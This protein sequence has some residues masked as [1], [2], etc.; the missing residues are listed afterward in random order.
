[1]IL[2]GENMFNV[3]CRRSLLLLLAV[4]S[5]LIVSCALSPQQVTIKPDITVGAAGYGKGRAISVQAEDLRENP[6]IGT[7]GGVYGNTST[8]EIGN[9]VKSEIA[10]AVAK[11][12]GNWGFK[13]QVNG[14]DQT[15]TMVV[16]LSSLTYTLDSNP[17]IGKAHVTATIT[18]DVTQGNR[19]YHGSYGAN[20]EVGYIAPPPEERN[21][22]QIN[23][24]I[25][26]ALQKVF[27][28]E[29]L[30]NFLQ[31]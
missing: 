1:L 6:V 27:E 15:M 30:I 14:S 24:A 20:N 18:V 5:W 16:A 22:T 2:P 26:I 12:L 13:P 21:N 11:G 17:A 7:R 29:G 9:D 19:S 25:S 28:D 23:E 4:S 10:F 8:I 3:L 31:P